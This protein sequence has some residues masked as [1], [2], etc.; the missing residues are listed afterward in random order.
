MEDPSREQPS[1]ESSATFCFEGIDESSHPTLQRDYST[2]GIGPVFASPL[3][4]HPLP[5]SYLVQNDGLESFLS[6]ELVGVIKSQPQDFLVREIAPSGRQVLGLSKE[7]VK[8]IR[9][10]DLYPIRPDMWKEQEQPPDHVAATGNSDHKPV[11]AT[12][13]DTKESAP[14]SMD[15]VLEQELRRTIEGSAA[16]LAAI[17]KLDAQAKATLGGA[18]GDTSSV[19][20]EIWIT[21]LTL[22]D[23]TLNRKSFHQAF[24]VQYPLLL[25]E[26]V[27]QP[28]QVDEQEDKTYKIRVTID[29]RFHELVP[30]LNDPCT[31]LNALYAFF[32]RKMD[33][34]CASVV[35]VLKHDLP[36]EERR[37]IHQTISTKTNRSLTTSTITD[38][39]LPN[40]GLGVAVSVQW[41][42]NACRRVAN[43]QD[44]AC[45]VGA[46]S[47]PHTLFVL[48]KTQ[49]EHLTVLQT[50][51]RALKVP[52]PDIGLAGIKDLHAVTYQFATL[53][54]TSP[55]R[56]LQQSDYLKSN[57]IEVG[58]VY[59]VN[60]KLNKGQLEGNRFEIVLRNVRQVQVDLHEGTVLERLVDADM[61]RVEA[62]VG[63]AREHGFVNFYGSQRVGEP[64]LLSVVGVR[65][66]DI[67]R[68]MVQ[69]KFSEA[70]DL[71]M[72][73]RLV[74]HG[75]EAESDDIVAVRE[76]WKR[77]GGD[78]N[79]T[80][81]RLPRNNKMVRE[82]TI[83]QG[84]KRHGENNPLAAIRCLGYNERTFWVSAYQSYLFNVMTTTRLALYGSH[85][86][87]G[88]LVHSSS[89]DGVSFVTDENREQYTIFDVILPLPGH[90]V[91]FPSNE[92]GQLY[93]QLLLREHVTF[94]K[95]G[96]PPESMPKGSY[97]R[98]LR[99]A[100]NLSCNRWEDAS[101]V[102]VKLSFDL[103]AGSYATM[104]LRE[105]LLT[106][107]A[108]NAG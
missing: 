47:Y 62:M 96:A 42:K 26:S 100:T 36:R 37:I 3:P 77:S 29:D 41:S 6:S 20:N 13:P 28:Q 4:D 12:S 23:N 87:A 81:K 17:R 33:H 95:A 99:R 92:V 102:G 103:P 73:G 97:R 55:H 91:E 84:L 69:Q 57:G 70:I 76:T 107:V 43:K 1:H 53:A 49:K 93:K 105:L 90:G 63:R 75:S 44:R 85:V 5:Q 7:E 21:P 48:K 51:Q 50:L 52:L 64:G 106:T 40:G 35:V 68:A 15:E 16:S 54:N 34:S 108:R 31:D 94:D 82:R 79:L 74:C 18:T 22:L 83:L 8:S 89:T 67:G 58:T 65:G 2:I 27:L 38:F 39:I 32:K 10:A 78:V 101:G 60:W 46:S 71:L 59:K 19:T 45:S 72:T 9:I 104:F 86:V 61:S 98:I 66:F 24:R 25:A 14:M 88:D 80:Y 30:L 56:L 11:V